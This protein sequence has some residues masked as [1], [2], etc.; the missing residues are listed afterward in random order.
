MLQVNTELDKIIVIRCQNCGFYMNYINE[1][2]IKCKNCGEIINNIS[3]NIKYINK[4][5]KS[6]IINL[7]LWID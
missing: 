1:D 5:L 2:N 4:C 3:D 6:K 7:K